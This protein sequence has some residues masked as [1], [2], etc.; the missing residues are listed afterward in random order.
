MTLK[1]KFKGE[2]DERWHLVPVSDYTRS[3]IPLRAWMQRIL[4][5]R[6]I[7]EGRRS[8]WLFQNNKGMRDRFGMYDTTFC[9]LLDTAREESGELLPE[10]VDTEDF[11]LWRSPRRGA[12]L[13]T[14][15]QD[16]SE[17]VIEL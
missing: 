14:T 8:G 4:D 15:N 11:S 7:K 2:V 1:G 13:E 12:V 9:Q 5:C 6:V 3:G 17:K 16:V 10:V